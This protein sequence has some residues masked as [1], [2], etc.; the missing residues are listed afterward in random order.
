MR[1]K[2][3]FLL[4]TLLTFIFPS[5][6]FAAT[7][8]LVPNQGNLTPQVTT[9]I[10]I[11]LNSTDPVNVVSAVINYPV[12]LMDISWIKT[13]SSA[14]SVEVEQSTSNGQIRISRG[15][16]NPVNGSDIKVATVGITPKTAG[17][18]TLNFTDSSLALSSNGGSNL[19][20]IASSTGASFSIVSPTPTITLAP[21]PTPQ[22][23]ANTATNNSS[24]TPIPSP[25]PTSTDSTCAQITDTLKP[26][27]MNKYKNVSKTFVRLDTI[28]TLT[29]N[30]YQTKL[31]PKGRVFQ[32]FT[33]YNNQVNITRQTS[34]ITLSSLQSI[35]NNINCTNAKEQIENFKSAVVKLKKNL[36][37]YQHASTSLLIQLKGI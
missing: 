14:F 16:L 9:S 21:T 28:S 20:N 15:T 27:L 4:F 8:S 2:L 5:L 6:T 33:R 19:L 34:L 36:K 11:R 13:D 10:N 23:N 31:I 7:F 22:T 29:N 17:A 37:D 32:E 25:T 35:A 24:P 1:H 3:N 30:Y 18:A 12:N 26:K